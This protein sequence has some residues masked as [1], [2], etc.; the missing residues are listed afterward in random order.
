MLF[1][2]SNRCLYTG[3]TLILVVDYYDHGV[4]VTTNTELR[5]IA[6]TVINTIVM[7]P[8]AIKSNSTT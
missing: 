1:N 7:E 8:I 4:V 2:Y 3:L 6:P 5:I